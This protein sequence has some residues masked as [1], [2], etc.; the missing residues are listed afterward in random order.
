VC[1]ELLRWLGLQLPALQLLLLPLT[2]LPLTELLLALPLLGLAP[3]VGQHQ[4]HAGHY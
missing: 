3:A 2:L 1:L 4:V